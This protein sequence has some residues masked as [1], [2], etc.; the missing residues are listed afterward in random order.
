MMAA[1][2][3]FAVSCGKKY[4]IILS[5]TDYEFAPQGG[6]LTV[7][8]S[9]E[10][11]WNIDNCP[12]WVAVSANSGSKD[13]SIV[14]TAQPNLGTSLREAILEV[15]TSTNSAQLK[16]AQGFVEEEF[17]TIA[18]AFITTDYQGGEYELQI[19]SNCAWSLSE[20]SQQ[21]S[22]IS[23]NPIS[24]EGNQTV[25]VIVDRYENTGD[26]ASRQAT[27]IFAGSLTLVPV[28]IT[29]TDGTEVAVSVNPTSLRFATEG[30]TQQI[31]VTCISSWTVSSSVSW[32]S[33]SALE[34]SGNG[35][36]TVTAEA[37][38][39][40]QPR[41]GA[42]A[43]VSDAGQSTIVTVSQD[44][45]IDPH[46][47]DVSPLEVNFT[48]QGGS[49]EITIGCDQIWKIDCPESWLSFSSIIGEG[50]G[51]FEIIAEENVLNTPRNAVVL[52]VSEML[53]KRIQIH[54]EKGDEAPYISLNVDTLYVDAFE[55]I[56]TIEVASNV[57]WTV[58]QSVWAEPLQNSGQ[59]NGS[60]QLKI[61]ENEN[62]SPRTCTIRINAAGASASFVIVQS[63][64]VYTLETSETEIIAPASGLKMEI[65]VFANQNWTVSK[66]ASWI[67]YDP[68]SGMNDGSF[69]I[70]VDANNSPAD[71]SAE[72]YVTGEKDGLV[73]INVT[74]P[75]AK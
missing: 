39:L 26:E 60:F 58:G 12:D 7:Q 48:K 36:I 28:E 54:Q 2:L 61:Q 44:A 27:L 53:E 55:T 29:Q 73:I 64:Y 45:A 63:G 5:P 24:G 46:Y 70:V 15:S 25:K 50:D 75:H 17:I 23:V 38:E 65:S 19:T 8:I 41:L 59:G 11:D 47:L 4:E 62:V 22:W 52:V 69:S 74:Q 34:G 51:S 49:A 21:I 33:V 40:Y 14:L 72:I 68:V 9:T 32:L 1:L 57:S 71:R 20:A 6:E 18:P 3:I 56:S 35:Q 67:L 30:G 13:A 42:I 43:F 31:D 66:G 37:N 16:L 10:G